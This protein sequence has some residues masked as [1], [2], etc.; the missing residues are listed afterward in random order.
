LTFE[1]FMLKSRFLHS[2]LMN[3]A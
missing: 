3:F 1:V 2:G